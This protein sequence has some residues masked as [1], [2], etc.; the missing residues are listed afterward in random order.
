MR[1][2]KQKM[3]NTMKMLGHLERDSV[4]FIETITKLNMVELD[5]E[6]NKLIIAV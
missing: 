5:N 1:G 4:K 2:S 6:N 3:E